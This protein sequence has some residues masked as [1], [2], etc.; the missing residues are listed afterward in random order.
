MEVEEESS[1]SEEEQDEAA[2]EANWKHLYA[3]IF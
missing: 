3:I 1:A 2:M